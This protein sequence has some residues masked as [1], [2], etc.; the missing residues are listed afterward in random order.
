MKRKEKINTA[1]R[2]HPPTPSPCWGPI[3]IMQM[4]EFGS[5]EEEK[6][7]A[8]EKPSQSTGT[9]SISISHVHS[10]EPRPHRTSRTATMLTPPPTFLDRILPQLSSETPERTRSRR[11]VIFS[12]IITL[13]S[14]FL[15]GLVVLARDTAPTDTYLA[16]TALGLTAILL[17]GSGLSIVLSATEEWLE[18]LVYFA[19]LAVVAAD[20]DTVGG[21]WVCLLFAVT[22]V[23]LFADLPR[24]PRVVV[25]VLGVVWMG[26]RSVDLFEVKG[27]ECVGRRDAVVS[28]VVCVVAFLA[29]FAAKLAVVRQLRCAERLSKMNI[30]SSETDL[31]EVSELVQNLAVCMSLYD[32]DAAETIISSSSLPDTLLQGL[33]EILFH[34]RKYKPYIPVAQQP[35]S[36]GLLQDVCGSAAILSETLTDGGSSNS[37]DLGRESTTE[38]AQS[39]RSQSTVVTMVMNKTLAAQKR[40]LKTRHASV[41]LVVTNLASTLGSWTGLLS[42]SLQD[43]E[44]PVGH[45]AVEA[46]VCGYIDSALRIF[47]AKKGVVELFVGDRIYGSFNTSRTCLCHVPSAVYCAKEMVKRHQKMICNTSVCTGKVI[48]GDMG[49]EEMRRMTMFGQLPLL[50]GALER[51]GR[52]LGVPLIASDAVHA[53]AC[54]ENEMRLVP[55]LLSMM[56]HTADHPAAE[57]SFDSFPTDKS[58]MRHDNVETGSELHRG[59]MWEV[60]LNGQRPVESVVRR[61]NTEWMYELE[62]ATGRDWHK[63]NSALRKYIE[64]DASRF[65]ALESFATVTPK[66]IEMKNMLDSAMQSEPGRP[67]VVWV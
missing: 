37:L 44:D 36:S 29:D 16:Y 33:R 26:V 30:A 40:E 61:R 62:V 56:K 28:S 45:V 57:D 27:E 55:S 18:G 54:F 23:L 19:T 6:L 1:H 32:L 63:Y 64:G 22:D 17:L 58:K 38:F 60:I 31:A 66:D 46:Y 3:D 39:T 14:A 5:I 51:A 49:C 20:V 9:P 50:A 34:I 67:F 53:D 48:C 42:P 43:P 4:Q 10:K 47:H 65:E 2:S 12:S 52:A 21:M 24:R 25:V 59:V 8:S 35:V 7:P 13:L 41:S 15:L 11:G